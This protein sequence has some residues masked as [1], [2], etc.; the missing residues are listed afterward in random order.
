MGL[1]VLAVSLAAASTAV[2]KPAPHLDVYV[3]DVSRDAVA[4][5][6]ALGVD[7]HEL[8]LSEAA[9]RPENASTSRRS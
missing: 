3:G 6:V 4:K 8:D 7:R 9:W 5:L 1:S 2:A